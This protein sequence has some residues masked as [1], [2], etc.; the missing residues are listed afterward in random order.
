[1]DTTDNNIDKIWEKV[2]E[3]NPDLMNDWILCFSSNS[4]REGK[5]K[6]KQEIW[7]TLTRSEYQTDPRKNFLWRLMSKEPQKYGYVAPNGEQKRRGSLAM[8]FVQVLMENSYWKDFIAT[9]LALRAPVTEDYGPIYCCE[10]TTPLHNAARYENVDGVKRLLAAGKRMQINPSGYTPLHFA[11]MAINPKPEIAKLLINP[12]NGKRLL[13]IQTTDK[14]GRNT[15][16]HIAAANVKVT[17]EFIQQFKDANPLL[18]NSNSDTPFHVAA[19]SSNLKA[20]IYMLN[21]FEPTN[22]EWDVDEVDY[23]GQNEDQGMDENNLLNICARLANAS[24]ENDEKCHHRSNRLDVNEAEQPQDTLIKICARAGNAEAVELLIK[25]GADISQGV[26]HEIVIESVRNPEK[27]NDLLRVYQSVVDNA[28]TWRN[29]EEDSKFLTVEGSDD[30]AERFRKTMIWLLTTPNDDYGGEDVLQCALTYGASRMFWSIINTKSVFRI[31]GKEASRF[32]N[33]E[34]ESKDVCNTNWTVFDVT[35][36]T[37]ENMLKSNPSDS[38]S[39]RQQRPGGQQTMGKPANQKLSGTKVPVSE[40]TALCSRSAQDEHS[41]PEPSYH[42]EQNNLRNTPKHERNFDVIRVL[43]KP[44]LDRLLSEFHLWKSSNVLS[45]QPFNELTRPYIK[46][47]QRFYFVLGLLQLIFMITFTVYWMPTTC[48]LALMFNVSTIGCSSYNTE[49]ARLSSFSQQRSWIAMFWLIWPLI[50]FAENAFITYHYIKQSRTAHTGKY[51]KT[52]LNSKD[53]SLSFLS[54]LATSLLKNPGLRVFCV[55]MLVWL[56]VYFWT[57]SHELYVDVTSMVFLFGWITNLSFFGAVSKNVSISKAVVD[58]IIIKDISSFML[59]F[60]FN[61]VGFSFAMHTIRT[62]ACMANQ[63]VSL[64]D[65]FFAVL[66]SAFGIG[67]FF[68]AASTDPV[69]MAS[70]RTQTLFEFVYLG[71][72]C[73]TMIVLLNILI[74]MINSRY[75]K[76]KRKAEN[77]WRFETLS[78]MIALKAV[79]CFGCFNGCGNENNKLKLLSPGGLSFNKEF[80]RYYLRLLLPVDQRLLKLD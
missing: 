53:Q 52:V 50:L 25:H 71:Y 8:L 76:A 54:K 24:T 20:I 48:S 60:G 66:S 39:S 38:D 18:L 12:D 7:M 44:Y 40:G 77:I 51:L 4:Y 68:D 67:D 43:Q 35:N 36:F 64:H 79:G 56:Y 17:E 1:M 5:D 19:K 73:T 74:A 29:L 16:L 21:T 34:N 70:R 49:D 72:V 75:E 69:C 23:K 63:N 30:Y 45:T 37:T 61:V 27:I 10:T 46:F 11:S 65:T 78:T 26:L 62:S 28:V 59:F 55:M 31:D 3:Q 14:C 57:D 6:S 15:A 47:V 22:N 58:K 80:N 33:D 42:D 32:V 41:Q 9:T 2:Y 13:N